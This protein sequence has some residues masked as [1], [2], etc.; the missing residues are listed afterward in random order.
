MATMSAC[1]NRLPPNPQIDY[2][3]SHRGFWR[4]GDRRRGRDAATQITMVERDRR[5]FR[6]RDPRCDVESFAVTSWA[7]HLRQ[8]ER[9]TNQRP[10]RGIVV[11]RGENP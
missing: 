10:T 8:H 7:E 11:R 2:R 4:R 3:E 5:V 6:N 9:G 1:M